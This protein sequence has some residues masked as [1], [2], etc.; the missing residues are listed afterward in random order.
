MAG[1]VGDDPTIFRVR[2]GYVT[3]YTICQLNSC[4]NQAVKLSVLTL[5]SRTVLPPIIRSIPAGGPVPLPHRVGVGISERFP[6]LVPIGRHCMRISRVATR[7]W[8]SQRERILSSLLDVPVDAQRSGF[9]RI[10]RLLPDQAPCSMLRRLGIERL[11]APIGVIGHAFQRVKLVFKK[12]VNDLLCCHHDNYK[13]AAASGLEP[14][15]AC[16]KGTGATLHYA[17][18]NGANKGSRTPNLPVKSRLLYQLSY[19]RVNWCARLDLNQQGSQA[20]DLW[21]LPFPLNHVRIK[22]LDQRLLLPSTQRN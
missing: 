14:E 10:R 20:L 21:G 7:R 2:A 15:L 12:A 11:G 3:N 17:A 13:V 18:K 22:N 16:S 8:L 9:A 19:A 1:R 4:P 6:T 5:D